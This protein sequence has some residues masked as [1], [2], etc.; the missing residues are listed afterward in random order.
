MKF[1]LSLAL[2]VSLSAI[3][4]AAD[5]RAAPERTPLGAAVAREAARLAQSP[6]SSSAA[7]EVQRQNWVVRHP[8]LVGTLAGLG[9]G[10][11]LDA[12]ARSE[13]SLPIVP[14]T[15]VGPGVGVLGG[16]VASA[17]IKSTLTYRS[18]SHPDAVEVNRIV[19]RLGV[20]EMVV[21]VAPNIGEITGRIQ[22][23]GADDFAVTPAG[24]PTLRVRYSDVHQIRPKPLGTGVKVAVI[25]SV[26]GVATFSTLCALR[27]GG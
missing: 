17:F 25:G 15:L 11:A 5:D 19:R 14:W 12:N 18:G 10:V 13:G 4:S 3:A 21:L 7:S 16:L 22:A 27:C 26:I 8:A 20:G 9:V 24:E 2:L 6:A 23:I 1:A